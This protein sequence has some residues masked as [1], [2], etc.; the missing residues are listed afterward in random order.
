MVLEKGQSFEFH[1]ADKEIALDLLQGACA[2]LGRPAGGGFQGRHLR[3]NAAVPACPEG[4]AGKVAART[5]AELYVQKTDNDRTFEAHLYTPEEVVVQRAGSQG[6]LMGCMRRE[7]KTFFDYESAPWSNM[8]LGEVLNY[9]G[10]WSSYP[11]HHH[12]QPE[13]YFYRFDH[14]TASARA[15]A[16][17]IYETATTA[18]R[19]PRL[20]FP[21]NYAGYAMCLCGDQV[22]RR[23]R[24]TRIDDPSTPG[25]GATPTSTFSEEKP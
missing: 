21:G 11:P 25:C 5:H 2:F 12:P 24:V 1:E 10:K 17:E 16:R 8:V 9:P 15:L 7:I 14:P 19:Q 18:E 22:C 4:S 3:D 20:P 23:P 6:E 13:V